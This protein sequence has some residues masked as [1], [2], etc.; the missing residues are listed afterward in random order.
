MQEPYSRAEKI[1]GFPQAWTVFPSK[2]NKA[3]IAIVNKNLKPAIIASKKSIQN[4][5][6]L[7]APGHTWNSSSLP[8]AADT[9]TTLAPGEIEK[10]K[11]GLA[12]HPAECPTEEQFSLIEGGYNIGHPHIHGCVEDRKRC[13]GSILRLVRTKYSL[14]MAG[15][16]ARLQYSFLDGTSRLET[17]NR[18][19]NQPPSPANHH[20]S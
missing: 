9:L 7:G 1:Q 10:E 3:A 14:Q 15:K 4:H 12:A 5:S 16:T 8:P 17:R 20:S 13:T 11:A 6:N 18:L 19:C 2:T